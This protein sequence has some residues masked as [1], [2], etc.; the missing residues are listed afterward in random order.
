[1]EHNVVHITLDVEAAGGELSRHSTLSI[2]ACVVTREALT[3][4]EYF[5]RGQ[6]FYTELQPASLIADLDAMRVGCSQLV[7]LEE[8][9]LT[10]P[11]FDVASQEFDPVAVLEHMQKVCEDPV[12]AIE[13]FSRWITEVCAGK[14]CIGVTDTVF[15]DGQLLFWTVY[16]RT[17]TIWLGRLGSG[18]GLSGVSS[19]F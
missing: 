11:R 13:R 3:F 9:R 6:V 18:F 5:T 15:F 1:M 17:I 14:K 2:G 10:D 19:A 8:K 16:E 12:A 4:E 7:C